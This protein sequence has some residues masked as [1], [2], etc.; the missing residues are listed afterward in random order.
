VKISNVGSF[1]GVVY[2]PQSVIELTNGGQFF[3]AFVGS[4]IK[5]DNGSQVHYDTALRGE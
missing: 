3:G 4:Q 5:L 1:Y 2:A